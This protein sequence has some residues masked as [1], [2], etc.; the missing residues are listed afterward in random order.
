MTYEY[1]VPDEDML[2]VYETEDPAKAAEIDR[3]NLL[4]DSSA[5]DLLV[6]WRPPTVITVTPVD[7]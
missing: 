1:E 4:D 2:D 6:D 7:E 5:I 3:Q